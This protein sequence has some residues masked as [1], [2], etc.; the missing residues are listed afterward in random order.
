MDLNQDPAKLKVL[1]H[2]CV[3]DART[4]TSTRVACAL[5]WGVLRAAEIIDWWFPVK[6]AEDNKIN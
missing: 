6:D 1:A 2:A 4:K 5:L 3:I